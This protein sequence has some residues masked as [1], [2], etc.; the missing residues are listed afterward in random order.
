VSYAPGSP[1]E[2]RAGKSR[3]SLGDE[4]YLAIGKHLDAVISHTEER[5]LKVNYMA[6]KVHSYDLLARLFAGWSA[7]GSSAYIAR[8]GRRDARVRKRTTSTGGSHSES[9]FRSLSSALRPVGL[10]IFRDVVLLRHST[11][12]QTDCSYKKARRKMGFVGPGNGRL[13]ASKS[14]R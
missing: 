8:W 7:Q 3:P 10:E 12:L 11:F 1:I 2:L 14:P 4:G 13:T 9:G 6:C 5:V